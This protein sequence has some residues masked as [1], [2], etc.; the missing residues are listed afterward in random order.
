MSR[1]ILRSVAEAA[2][3]VGIEN[4]G[5]I[6]ALEGCRQRR[7]TT[8]LGDLGVDLHERRDQR[9]TLALKSRE[10]L[11]TLVTLGAKSRGAR[12]LGC[13][14]ST[15]GAVLSIR[16]FELPDRALL[17]TRVAEPRHNCKHTA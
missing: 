17:P 9:A 13:A 16:E 12:T 14:G 6:D 4:V 5:R 8:Q 11:V 2:I 1:T 7:A 10:L 3:G 15:R